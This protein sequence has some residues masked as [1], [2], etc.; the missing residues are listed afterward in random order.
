[1]SV[2]LATQGYECPGTTSSRALTTHGYEC[3]PGDPPQLG[4]FDALI[5]DVEEVGNL[6][7]DVDEV[8]DLFADVEVVS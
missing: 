6:T 4:S 5:A 7:A 8:G 3:I 2:S 1:M